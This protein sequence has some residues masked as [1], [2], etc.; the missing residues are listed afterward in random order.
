[1][2]GCQ[3]EEEDADYDDGES[4]YSPEV[5]IV[6]SFFLSLSN[7][8]INKLR[9]LHICRLRQRR[10]KI[11]KPFLSE[12]ISIGYRFIRRHETC[13]DSGGILSE[14]V[15]EPAIDTPWKLTI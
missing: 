8:A 3:L 13:T 1:M 6:S 11:S 10:P 7:L 5:S 12:I 4:K 14:V 2:S 15:D 9:F